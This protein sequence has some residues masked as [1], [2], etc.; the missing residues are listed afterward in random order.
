MKKFLLSLLASFAIFSV[1]AQSYTEDLVV[2]INGNSSSPIT[3]MVDVVKNA[4]KT[5]SFHLK[6]FMLTNGEGFGA[7]PV[8]NILLEGVTMTE[9]GGKY[10]LATDQQIEITPG[11]HPDVADGSFSNGGGWLGPDLGIVPILLKGEMNEEHLWVEI[12]IDMSESIGDVVNV[13]LGDPTL[14]GIHGLTVGK[15]SLKAVYNLQ[16][17]RVNNLEKGLYIVD[18]KKIIK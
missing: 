13:K 14:L 18:G 15:S 12:D 6:N 4:D 17:L 8:G 10:V 2:T 3:T 1:S 11:S 16:G 5:C 9:E 7:I